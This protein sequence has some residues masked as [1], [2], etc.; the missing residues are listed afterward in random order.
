MAPD[1]RSHSRLVRDPRVWC[2]SALLQTRVVNHWQECYFC[3]IPINVNLTPELEGLI[4][5]KVSSGRY[6]S[7]SEVVREA[8]RL[9]EAEDQLRAAKLAQLRHEIQ[10]GLH[11]GPARPWNV[12]EMKREGR[13]RLA[14]RTATNRK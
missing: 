3:P 7:A 12:A 2:T 5:Q 10:D 9:M 8:L 4:R 6:N 11:S 13:K 14:A 1:I